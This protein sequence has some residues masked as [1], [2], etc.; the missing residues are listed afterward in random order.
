MGRM[1]LTSSPTTPTSLE[2][3]E[4][5]RRGDTIVF[6]VTF[7][8]KGRIKIVSFNIVALLSFINKLIKPL[9]LIC[10][11]VSITST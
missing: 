11:R 7:Y 6:C 5:E 1:L 3:G 10:W 2:T 8:V 9:P 4:G